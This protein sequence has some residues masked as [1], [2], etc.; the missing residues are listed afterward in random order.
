MLRLSLQRKEVVNAAIEPTDSDCDWPSD[1]EEEDE[2]LAVNVCFRSAHHRTWARNVT[3]LF[4]CESVFNDLVRTCIL[5]VKFLL[6]HGES[7]SRNIAGKPKL[8]HNFVVIVT[9]FTSKRCVGIVFQE[10]VKNKAKISENGEK[11]EED[12]EDG[13]CVRGF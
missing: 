12:K 13:S 9:D 11:T 7:R 3:F 6:F 5:R 4:G 1:E 10:D 8:C 2:K